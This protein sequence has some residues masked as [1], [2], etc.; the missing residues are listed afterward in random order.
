MTVPEPTAECVKGTVFEACASDEQLALPVGDRY[1]LDDE[2]IY[3][4]RALV[5]GNTAKDAKIV[6]LRAENAALKEDR[7]AHIKTI[8][9]QET[10][11]RNLEGRLGDGLE[12]NPLPGDFE[13][14]G[15]FTLYAG[16]YAPRNITVACSL[17]TKVIELRALV[18]E[19]FEGDSE[20]VP[21][22]WNERA[23]RALKEDEP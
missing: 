21:W 5:T 10:S 9:A 12:L 11:I 2:Q 17:K 13:D 20:S 8:E 19:I 3:S 6:A 16:S 15:G 22:E 7:E 18:K 14:R 23:R 4:I 1:S